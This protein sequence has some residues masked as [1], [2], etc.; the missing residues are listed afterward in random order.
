VNLE[1]CA[2]WCNED[3]KCAG[4]KWGGYL[5]SNRRCI[6]VYGT[7]LKY[8]GNDKIE[9]DWR[10]YRKTSI[11]PSGE[12]VPG[13]YELLGRGYAKNYWKAKNYSPVSKES[14]FRQC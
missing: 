8:K 7:L 5:S 14:C 6:K 13:K 3:K 2:Y 12:Y 4:I 1:E 9:R 11:V 10:A